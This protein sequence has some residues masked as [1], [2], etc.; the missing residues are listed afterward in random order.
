LEV[1]EDR[2]K[3]GDLIGQA[4]I[5]RLLIRTGLAPSTDGQ[6]LATPRR[7][8]DEVFIIKDRTTIDRRV[9]TFASQWQAIRPIALLVDCELQERT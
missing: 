3:A 6:P 2:V 7:P 9:G 1:G 4:A 8:L 5:P